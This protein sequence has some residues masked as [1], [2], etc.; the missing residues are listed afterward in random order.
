MKTRFSIATVMVIVCTLITF[1]LKAQ[2]AEKRV[3]EVRKAYAEAVKMTKIDNPY[4]RNG[5]TVSLHRNLPGSGI[6]E[7]KIEF[8]GS[9]HS[10]TD[11]NTIFE[12]RLI[13]V[14][15][16]IAERKFYE[17]YLYD[18]AGDPMF[19]FYR[20][21]GIAGDISTKEEQRYYYDGR[22]LSIYSYKVVDAESGILY[23]PYDLP[24]LYKSN[25]GEDYADHIL[26]FDMYRGLF[27]TIMNSRY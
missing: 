10:D 19:Y 26:D 1:P 16:N 6:Q 13:R 27:N 4:E 8:F 2:F 11:F 20:Y 21:D 7:K 12:V 24:E 5:M 23:S 15:Y 22:D 9:A 14:S 17:E 18:E 3:Q 25:N